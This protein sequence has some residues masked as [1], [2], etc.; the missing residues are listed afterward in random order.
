MQKMRALLARYFRRYGSDFMR[1]EYRRACSVLFVAR[2]VSRP[3]SR[4][5][6]SSI[7]G[8]PWRVS[9]KQ[10][11]T[12]LNFSDSGGD[13]EARD[14]RAEK[15]SISALNHVIASVNIRLPGCIVLRIQLGQG[16]HPSPIQDRGSRHF[17]ISE[18]VH[19]ARPSRCSP[20]LSFSSRPP[21]SCPLP[22]CP[23]RSLLLS[24]FYPL[25]SLYHRSVSSVV[26]SCHAR[27][28]LGQ[29]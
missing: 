20:A 25:G 6:L 8:I 29:R 1:I 18:A 5:V 2:C 10:G 3:V 19:C 17:R 26:L 28:P 22:S 14:R 11:R 16:P 15:P 24:R 13:G 12:T 27:N 9:A 7:S 4:Q 21:G 23:R